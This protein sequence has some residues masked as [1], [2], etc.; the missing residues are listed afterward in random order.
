VTET[1]V[2]F[3]MGVITRG[4]CLYCILFKR[5]MHKR[6]LSGVERAVKVIV[7]YLENVIVNGFLQNSKG[8]FAFYLFLGVFRRTLC[9]LS[10]NVT[11]NFLK[12]ESRPKTT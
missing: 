6:P 11:S 3:F 9:C 10:L 8:A 2:F 4:S 12:M 7:A 1:A 5:K